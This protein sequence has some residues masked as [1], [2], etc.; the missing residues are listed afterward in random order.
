MISEP[1]N[2]FKMK[3][4]RRV[5]KNTSATVSAIELKPDFCE[6]LIYLPKVFMIV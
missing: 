1:I 5:I 3:M 2:R 6:G 4:A